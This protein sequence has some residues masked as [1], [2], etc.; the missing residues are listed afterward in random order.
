MDKILKDLNSSTGAKGSVVVT[1]D[2]MV[3]AG[4]IHWEVE[5]DVVGALSSFLV[6]ATDRCLQQ[7]KMGKLNRMTM[8][9]THGKLIIVSLQGYF[10]VVLVD[11]FAAMDQVTPRIDAAGHELIKLTQMK[12]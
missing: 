7:G 1:H 3:V 4:D 5:K 9:A 12:V 10:L 8:I 2:G 11:Q 6:M